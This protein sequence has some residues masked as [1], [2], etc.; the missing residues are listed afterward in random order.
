MPK[1]W[2]DMYAPNQANPPGVGRKRLRQAA[3]QPGAEYVPRLKW[4]QVVPYEGSGHWEFDISR[5]CIKRGLV[6]TTGQYQG[7]INKYRI[8]TRDD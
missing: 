6:H 4:R 2:K 7:Q 3:R 8:V 5:M 1:T